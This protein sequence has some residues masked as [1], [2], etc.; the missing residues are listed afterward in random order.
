MVFNVLKNR[1]F[2]NYFSS[3]LISGFGVGVGTVSANWFMMDQTGSLSAVGFMLVLNVL[4]GLAISPL[5]GT[6]TDK[7]N[8]KTIIHVLNWSRVF[9]LL[10]IASALLFSDFN[11]IY[12]YLFTIVNGMG[13]AV[14]MSV[15][16]SLVQELL[17]EKDLLNGNSLIEISL[18]V[19]MFVAG[20]ASGVLYKLYGF[21]IILI[22]N[23]IAFIISSLFLHRIQYTP[24]V[25]ATNKEKS[26]YVNFKEGLNYLRQQP[27]V[28]LLGLVSIVP[29]VSV[30]VFNVVLPG[31]V[32]GPMNGDSVV[33]GLSDMFY[34]IGGF[35]SGFVAAPLAKKLSNSKAVLVFFI[36]AIS[37][38]FA[39]VFNRYVWVLYIGCVLFGLSNSSLRIVMNAIIMKVVPKSFMGRAMSVWLGISYM[40]QCISAMGL[41]A[42]MDRFSPRVGF[43]GIGSLMLCSL[44]IA[45]YASL[46]RK[47]K[48]PH[49]NDK[50]IEEGVS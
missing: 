37:I 22:L 3:D 18:Q 15:S 14:Y 46:W 1:S 11:V 6:V 19:G 8:R 25:V 29:I 30:M 23:A 45:Y 26:F 31:Y 9:A 7:F 32:S 17:S 36:T 12:L 41:G 28:F 5:I 20:G 33:F 48:L 16:R 24:T 42:L 50:N 35:L 40:L 21:G 49:N 13:W 2:R 4:A 39:W 27:S 34:G 10:A 43:V 47:Q 44:I 38:Q